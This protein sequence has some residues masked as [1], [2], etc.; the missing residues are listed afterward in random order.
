MRQTRYA[1][2][3][4]GSPEWEDDLGDK[5]GLLSTTR[6]G[7]DDTEGPR[8]RKGTSMNP[9]MNGKQGDVK[10]RQKKRRRRGCCHRLFRWLLCDKNNV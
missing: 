10:D 6:R 3:R 5:V 7:D 1:N 4:G 9:G 8:V 2:S